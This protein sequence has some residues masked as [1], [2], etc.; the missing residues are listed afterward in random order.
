MEE[1]QTILTLKSRTRLTWRVMRIEI[2][3]F[4]FEN[5]WGVKM[6]K[7]KQH[8]WSHNLLK[9]KELSALLQLE[10]T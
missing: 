2:H 4:G 10:P 6:V 1:E 7:K 9:E 5:V 3:N 8:T